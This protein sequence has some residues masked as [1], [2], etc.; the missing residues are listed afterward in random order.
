M[1]AI[2]A[3]NTPEEFAQVEKEM[4]DGAEDPQLRPTRKVYPTR[5]PTP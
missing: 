2:G 1:G 5:C 4:I 3:I